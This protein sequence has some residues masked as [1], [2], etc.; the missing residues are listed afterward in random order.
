MCP[1]DRI[2]SAYLACILLRLH[3]I[4][5]W[6]KKLT[7]LIR[8]AGLIITA[9]HSHRAQALKHNQRLPYDLQL[10]ARSVKFLWR[11]VFFCCLGSVLTSSEEDKWHDFFCLNC[12]G[13]VSFHTYSSRF[14]T[15]FHS[16]FKV[17]P[18]TLNVCCSPL[19]HQMTFAYVRKW[20][21]YKHWLKKTQKAQQG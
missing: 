18:S 2:T 4:R 8:Q 17:S 9:I 6:R 3:K 13:P 19:Q 5:L 20:Q 1:Q 21:N 12:P 15:H 14:V 7:S 11:F 16:I 10:V